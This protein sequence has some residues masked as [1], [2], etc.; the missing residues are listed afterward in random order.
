VS[1]AASVRRAGADLLPATPRRVRIGMPQ[2][3][4]GGLSEGWLYR[5]CGDLH[6]E[7]I[8]RELGVTSDGFRGEGGDR[9]YPTVVALRARYGAP[10]ADVREND[11]LD[12]DVR[13]TPCGRACA[14]GRLGLSAAGQTSSV[15]LVTTFAVHDRRAGTLRMAVPA[16]ELAARWRPLADPPALVRL[17]KAA[18]AGL[19]LEDGDRPLGVWTLEPS[20]YA[21]YNGAGLL[22]FAA[23][24]TLADTA[25]RKLVS[26]LSP[27]PGQGVE[28]ATAT[29]VVARDVFFYANLPLGE[30][31][32]AQLMSFERRGDSVKTH[33]RLLRAR[34]AIRMAD[35]VTERRFVRQ[36]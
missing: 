7:A 17:A 22:Y 32:V 15:E 28:W 16:P 20:P 13:V 2:L 34:G 19:L 8:G 1:A 11:V 33:V 3:D 6:W 25:E 5:H 26:Q 9:L 18:R 24:P 35:L 10:L 23:Y 29:S 4:P 21:D 12:A 36:P 30:S 14:H 31:L 27:A